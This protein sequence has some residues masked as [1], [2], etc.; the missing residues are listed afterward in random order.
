M[1]VTGTLLSFSTKIL[2]S[3]SDYRDVSD[4]TKGM[5]YARDV[6]VVRVHDCSCCITCNHFISSSH[7]TVT[8]ACHSLITV[9]FIG[10]YGDD[11]PND[12]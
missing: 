11:V 9:T 5:W 8:T 4:E 10:A 12:D 6:I 3:F 1:I 7:P 2:D